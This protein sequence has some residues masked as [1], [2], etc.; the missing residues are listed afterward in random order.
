MGSTDYRL[1]CELLNWF[2]RMQPFCVCVR[3]RVRVRVRARARVCVCVCVCA[4]E[5]E[6]K[7]WLWCLTQEQTLMVKQTAPSTHFL[8]C[9]FTLY[10]PFT[11]P[12]LPPMLFGHLAQYKLSA[13]CS[14]I[15][16]HVWN[17]QVEDASVNQWSRQNWAQKGITWR[18]QCPVSCASL[19]GDWLPWVPWPTQQDLPI[20]SPMD[21]L[22]LIGTQKGN[23]SI[24][25]KSTVDNPPVLFIC[26]VIVEGE[27]WGS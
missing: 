24:T 7:G 12:P 1:L 26:V 14:S 17:V 20:I 9:S 22:L 11:S 21:S 19:L 27:Q 13:S 2:D 10:P 4:C 8:A 6:R 16:R 5:K 18:S 23:S 25:V 15:E 3:V